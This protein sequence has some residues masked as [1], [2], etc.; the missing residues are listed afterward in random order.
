[1]KNECYPNLKDI[2]KEIDLEMGMSPT[3]ITEDKI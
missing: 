3:H 1:M 2:N